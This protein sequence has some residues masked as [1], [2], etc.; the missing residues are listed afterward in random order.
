LA[1]AGKDYSDK[2]LSVAVK[3]GDKMYIPTD[4]D[5]TDVEATAYAA[6][7]IVKHQGFN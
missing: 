1:L 2:L 6:L 4:G 5:A 3:D 7:A